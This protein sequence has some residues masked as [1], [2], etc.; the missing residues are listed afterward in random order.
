MCRATGGELFD[1]LAEKDTLTEDEAAKF[2]RHILEGIDCM[3]E[4]NIVHLD[5]KVLYIVKVNCCKYMALIL[6]LQPENI[7]LK[8]RNKSEVVI[9][10]LGLARDLN[11]GEVKVICGTPEF[12]GRNSVCGQIVI[13]LFGY[14]SCCF[15]FLC[16]S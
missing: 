3:H 16:S 8:D 6:H 1:Y 5:L 12:I 4:K 9:I 10:D 14:V 13:A 2:T 11:K 15:E 7:M